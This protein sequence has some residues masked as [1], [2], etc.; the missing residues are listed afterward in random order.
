MK[1]VVMMA[2]DTALVTIMLTVLES[3][4]LS[5]QITSPHH[6]HGTTKARYGIKRCGVAHNWGTHI[7]EAY[8]KATAA[9]NLD[10]GEL[11]DVQMVS[12]M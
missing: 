4:N 8:T 5:N 7:K 6:K 1:V 11:A 2:A 10:K 12:E 9:L 3:S